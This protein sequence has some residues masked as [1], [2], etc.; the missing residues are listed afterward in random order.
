MKKS[1][2]NGL[3][4][5]YRM[6]IRLI[7][8]SCFR[9]IFLLSLLLFLPVTELSAQTLA[10]EEDESTVKSSYDQ[11]PVDVIVTGFDNF[12]VDAIYFKN[13]M[14]CVN[15]E[16]LFKA[17]KIPCHLSKD[18]NSMTGFI[19][20]EKHSYSIDLATNQIKSGTKS[21]N[22]KN[23]LVKEQGILYLESTQFSEV[24]GISLTFNYR[25][26][27]MVLKSNFELP[28]LKLQRNEKM[29]TN[30]SKVKGEIKV[31]TILKRD[32]HFLK[33]GT[34]DW[35]A[36]SSS[37]F[38]IS[39]SY[40]QLGLGIGT[41]FLFG[42]ADV[43]VNLYDQQKFS[44]N[45][46]NYIW[47]WIDNDKSII[48]QAL[49]GKL[50]VSSIAFLNAPVIGATV[51]NSPT[52]VRK[53]SGYYN[54]NEK[55][56][57]NWTVEL[58]INN[59]LV[60]YTTADATGIYQFKVPVVY[61]YTSLKLKFYGPLG[62]ERTEER[63]MNVPYTIMSKNEF[64]YGLTGGMVQD[65]ILSRY[66]KAD[67][68]YGVS[69]FLTVGGGM[70]YL[71]SIPNAP[72]I[73]FARIT[74]QPF[75]KLIVYAEYDQGVK[76]SG[77]VNYYLTRDALLEIDYTKYVEGQLATAFNALEERKAKFSFPVK[78]KK[79]NGFVKLDFSQLVY[80]S[81]NYNLADM[82][83]S[84]Y[85]NQLSINST[86]QLTWTNPAATYVSSDLSVSYRLKSGLT[87]RP[88]A[89]YIASENQLQSFD[90]T[91]EK[92]F[93]KGIF[94]LSYKRDFLSNDYTATLGFKYDLRFAKTAVS[95]SYNNGQLYTSESAQGS[96]AFGSGNNNIHTSNNSSIGKGGISFYPF[97]DLNQ[98]G[99]Y[100]KGEPMVKLNT[101]KIN[102]GNA[103]YSKKDSIVRIPDLNAFTDYV[104]E[105][106]N[107]DLNNIAWRFKKNI[108]KILID[109]NQ[110][111]RVDIPIIA[112]G[113]V[114]GMTSLNTNN[115]TK[116]IGRILVK[117]YRKNST[118]AVTEILSESDGYVYFL[119]LDP[120][121]YVARIDSEQL[122]ILNMVSS[123]AQISFKITPSIA[124]DI[125]DGLNFTLTPATE[126][127]AVTDTHF[128]T[129]ILVKDIITSKKRTGNELKVNEYISY[130]FNEG[131]I[132]QIG[133]YRNKSNAFNAFKKVKKISGKPTIVVFDHRFYKVRV[134]GFSNH[135]LAGKFAFKLAGL[136]FPVYYLPYVRHNF[137]IQIGEF[138]NRNDATDAL[139]NWSKITGKPVILVID[140]HDRYKVRIQGLSGKTE[141]ESILKQLNIDY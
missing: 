79:L 65:S 116:G 110:F 76:A 18:G 78:I 138:V 115:T 7:G 2:D 96:L 48:K 5:P 60:D 103:L 25:S 66:G 52:T 139:A 85:Y 29:R 120:G 130:I 113:E 129:S 95:A 24:F 118:K 97:L 72:Y 104:V 67:F 39:K 50:S 121:E 71:S 88:S 17:L 64:E 102:G 19:E 68:N 75:S 84:A 69:R 16:D 20:N 81:L 117:I 53:A 137:S 133:A 105:F 47:R 8:C 43:S 100:D 45:Q 6:Q 92:Y 83:F 59:V 11:I 56:E 98:N 28:V 4:V 87:I 62:E 57:P 14:L 40:N 70:E 89:S 136:K 74:L 124:G 32:Y 73:P 10:N 126:K 31:D 122:K 82:V 51:R 63:T 3:I 13:N 125:V 127:M 26:L 61:G 119:G 132:L 86:T 34:L 134:S 35:S 101:I 58:Y 23:G 27:S 106:N 107:N 37:Q 99:I 54:I 33:V 44:T 94:T 77:L 108:Y 49:V 141:A 135:I 140:E 15:I 46:L 36:S 131:V 90:L 93:P 1:D 42:E 41:E 22:P 80:T 123:P 91:I 55:T 112:V 128:N 114:S 30:M 109:P 12:T 111:K 21:I 38:G 9:L